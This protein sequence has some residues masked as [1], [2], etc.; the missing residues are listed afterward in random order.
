MFRKWP[1]G[2]WPDSVISV[3]EIQAED[4]AAISAVDGVRAWHGGEAKWSGYF[5]QH[6][7]GERITIVAQAAGAL[8]GYASMVWRSQHRPFAQAGIPEVQD[9]VVADT[10][11]RQGAATTMIV[12]LEMRARAAGHS[13][14]GI[15]FGLYA[16]YGPAQKLYV[17]RGYIPDGAGVTWN[18][19]LVVGGDPVRLD[20]DLVL[21]LTK[22]IS[23]A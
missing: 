14:V 4:V 13:V 20:D 7:C 17:R 6:L 23:A 22:E 19:Q 3:R 18:N 21:W 8:I 10:Y 15:G 1:A 2:R 12:A 16:D 5:R 11:R 9:M